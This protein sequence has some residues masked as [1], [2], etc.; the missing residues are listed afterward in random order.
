MQIYLGFGTP[1]TQQPQFLLW[2]GIA[3]WGLKI[4]LYFLVD[5]MEFFPFII[6]VKIF[7]L[8]FQEQWKIG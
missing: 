8:L 5:K 2:N 3:K 1:A 7:D 6:T 4:Y